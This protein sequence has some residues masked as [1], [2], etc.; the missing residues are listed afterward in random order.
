MNAECVFRATPHA[1]M[2][3]EHGLVRDDGETSLKLEVSY[4]YWRGRG[5]PRNRLGVPEGPDDDPEIEVT[6]AWTEMG[7]DVLDTLS[8]HEQDR[9]EEAAWKDL[10]RRER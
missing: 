1:T 8:K 4:A 6:E 10:A 3:F 2:S 7:E 9:L 5:G